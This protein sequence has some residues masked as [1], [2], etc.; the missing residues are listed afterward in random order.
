MSSVATKPVVAVVEADELVSIAPVKEMPSTEAVAYGRV[1]VTTPSA[2]VALTI[3]RPSP[4]FKAAY[5][6]PVL[7]ISIEA[8]IAAATLVGVDDAV[9]KALY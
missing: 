4:P 7:A 3:L 5:C 2:A 6:E 1:T 9:V 8:A